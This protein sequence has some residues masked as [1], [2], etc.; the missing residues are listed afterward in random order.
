MLI[1]RTTILLIVTGLASAIADEASCTNCF[2]QGLDARQRGEQERALSFFERACEQG[3][4]EACNAAGYM[5]SHG[6]GAPRDIS[7]AISLGTRSCDLGFWEGC[8]NLGASLVESDDPED[9][10]QG[11][12]LLAR[13]CEG[14][15]PSGCH[16]MGRSL[17]YGQGG[18]VDR[19]AAIRAFG[20]SCQLGF[21]P[22]CTRYASSLFPGDE[23][24]K[25]Q[26]RNLVEWACDQGDAEGCGYLGLA[27]RDGLGGS[28]DAVAANRNFERACDAGYLP[29]C[30][31]LAAAYAQGTGGLDVDLERAIALFETA[32]QGGFQY[33]CEN[34]ELLRSRMRQEPPEE[35]SSGWSTSAENFSF[36]FGGAPDEDGDSTATTSIGSMQIGQGNETATFSDVR[37]SCGVLQLTVAFGSA[38]A[39]LRQ[40][41]GG[42][43]TRRVTLTIEDGRIA[44]SSVDPNDGTGRCVISA[45]A[46]A[47]IDG[48]TCELE[49]SVSR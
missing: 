17:L 11:R 38:A 22:G 9:A 30:S 14:G 19:P 3:D 37:S 8:R 44:S 2:Q 32:C 12:A 7:R 4:G 16:A 18:A 10:T 39:P 45:L 48:M 33:S 24:D 43:D 15:S 40:C 42:S 41:L 27:L 25:A 34:L 23:D 36:S 20:R 1:I 29:F 13:A 31:E 46:R 35:E 26:A 21:A 5:L 6:E 47:R 28:V 49:A